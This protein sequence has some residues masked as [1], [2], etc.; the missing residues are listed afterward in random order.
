LSDASG[1]R[2][3]SRQA[4]GAKDAFSFDIGHNSPVKFI[5]TEI[6]APPQPALRQRMQLHVHRNASADKV[7]MATRR[8]AI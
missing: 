5:A 4:S 1:D 2:E 3:E 6:S 8:T 7:P